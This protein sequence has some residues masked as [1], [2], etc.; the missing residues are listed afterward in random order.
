L[1]SA[2][3]LYNRRLRIIKKDQEIKD[4]IRDL[5]MSALRAQMNP[6]FIFNCLNSI[7]NFISLN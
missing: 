3:I 7:Q 4:E 5:E 2:Y 6:H 1:I